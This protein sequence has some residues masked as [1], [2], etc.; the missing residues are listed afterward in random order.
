MPGGIEIRL[1]GADDVGAVSDLTVRSY[2][3]AGFVAAGDDYVAELGD[4][5][6]RLS[7]AELWVATVEG[8]V[9]ASVTFCPPGR[10]Y[11]ELAGPGEAEFRMLAVHPVARGLGLARA[12]VRRCFDRCA[13]LELTGMVLCSLPDM[14]AAHA[15]YASLGF[16]R[17]PRLDWRP[18]PGV[19]L[20]GF[21][22]TV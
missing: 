15:L 2:V 21:R 1:A 18:A 16:H 17:E 11:R 5:A 10:S 6:G 8:Q 3:D 14:T 9:R 12:L 13:E 7:G 20:L 4:A 22:A 19:V